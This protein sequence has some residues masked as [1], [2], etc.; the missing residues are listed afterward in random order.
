MTTA[1]QVSS[2][3]PSE[4]RV[5]PRSS[6]VSAG[7]TRVPRGASNQPAAGSR[8]ARSAGTATKGGFPAGWAD[9][10]GP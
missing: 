10:G 2:T 1:S 5:A 6:T 7:V 3:T 4:R 9:A 8:K